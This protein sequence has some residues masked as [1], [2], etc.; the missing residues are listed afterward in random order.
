MEKEQSFRIRH[1]LKR[2]CILNV[3]DFIV[4]LFVRYDRALLVFFLADS[5]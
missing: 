3:Y 4:T 2:Q 5:L 1:L